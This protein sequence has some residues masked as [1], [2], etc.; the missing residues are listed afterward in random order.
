MHETIALKYF[1]KGHT[2]MSAHSKHKQI[3]KELKNMGKVYDFDDFKTNLSK[4]KCQV[5]EM[6]MSCFPDL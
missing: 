5:I 6:D 1:E 2:C 4:A 3:E